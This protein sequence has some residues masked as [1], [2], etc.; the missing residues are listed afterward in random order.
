MRTWLPILCR[1]IAVMTENTKASREVV[2]VE[3]L[4]NVCTTSQQHVNTVLVASA[5]NMVKREEF[6]SRLATA[7]TFTTVKLNYQHAALPFS[8][9]AVRVVFFAVKIIVM[10]K[11]RLRCICT[12]ITEEVDAA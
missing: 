10:L 3:P 8:N 5:M 9:S 11:Q 4:H 6:I 12:V 1:L 7:R 2:S